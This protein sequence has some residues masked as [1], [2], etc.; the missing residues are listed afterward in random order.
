MPHDPNAP[1]LGQKL[2]ADIVLDLSDWVDGVRDLI[3]A[4]ATPS[5]RLANLLAALDALALRIGSLQ[6]ARR[7]IAERAALERRED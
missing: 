7:E 3:V 1:S 4:G 5:T 2:A 6:L